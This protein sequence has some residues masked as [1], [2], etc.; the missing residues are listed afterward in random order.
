[1]S[2]TKQNKNKMNKQQ[3]KKKYYVIFGRTDIFFFFFFNVTLWH[4]YL[5][6]SS[7]QLVCLHLLRYSF[8]SSFFSFLQLGFELRAMC[9]EPNSSS[10]CSGY[11]GDGVSSSYLP[12]LA[13]NCN[14]LDL[15]LPSSLEYRHEPLA[16]GQSLVVL[17]HRFRTCFKFT[18]KH[19]SCRILNIFKFTFHMFIA[20]ILK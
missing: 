15:S 5:V 1:M 8:Q 14:P 6:E 4:L 13:L 19:F 20:S 16:L 7:N 12:S 17:T 2:Q 3:R 9:L 18:H 10:F 11:F